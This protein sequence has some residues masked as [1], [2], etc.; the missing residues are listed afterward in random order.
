MSEID[1][2]PE[3]LRAKLN[4]ETS[5]IPWRELQRYFAAGMVVVVS[6]SLDLVDVAVRI[7]RDE[8]DLVAQWMAENRVARVP[9]DL[10]DAWFS[11]D[12]LLW[13]VVVKPWILVQTRAS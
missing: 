2:D 4:L 7:A 5:Q 10:A 13:T 8:K 9:D 1:Q 6:D 3:L 11:A 12:A